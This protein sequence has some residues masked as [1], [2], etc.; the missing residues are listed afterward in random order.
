MYSLRGHDLPSG[1]THEI[2]RWQ[3]EEGET[4][5]YRRYSRNQQSRAYEVSDGIGE[6]ARCG[7]QSH[8]LEQ[9]IVQCQMPEPRINGLSRGERSQH[10]LT[11]L[12]GHRHHGRAHHPEVMNNRE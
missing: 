10:S 4:D 2:K 6:K 3:V 9:V 5:R 12:N 1:K 7:S 11:D 8:Y